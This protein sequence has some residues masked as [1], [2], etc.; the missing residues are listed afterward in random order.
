MCTRRAARYK[1]G[2]S[3]NN[4]L[5]TMQTVLRLGSVTE[6]KVALQQQHHHPGQPQHPSPNGGGL[7]RVSSLKG[8]SSDALASNNVETKSKKDGLAG[9]AA[10]ETMST[11][12]SHIF[13][14]PLLPAVSNVE[15]TQQ[16]ATPSKKR[17]YSHSE[18]E[19]H[20]NGVVGRSIAETSFIRVPS[21]GGA[22]A[23]SK[24]FVNAGS[25]SPL[26]NQKSPDEDHDLD[27][28]ISEVTP[29]CTTQNSIE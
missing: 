6:T 11:S 9:I 22:S 4:T 3:T 7:S 8:K 20:M 27:H 16:E 13:D 25:K 28:E 12:M 2:Q 1:T 18:D 29:F 15:R 26:V 5:Q 17:N 24:G 21:L 23:T 19:D 10:A 14:H